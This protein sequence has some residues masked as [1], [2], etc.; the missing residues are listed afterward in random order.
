M[1]SWPPQD[2]AAVFGY[3]Y[4]TRAVLAVYGSRQLKTCP[5]SQPDQKFMNWE[6]PLPEKV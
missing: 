1:V 3:L 2:I 5:R 4:S 6:Q